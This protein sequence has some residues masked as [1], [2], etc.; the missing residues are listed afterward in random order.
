[1]FT[2]RRP[3]TGVFIFR[4]QPT[5]AFLTVCT[6]KR[7]RC[8]TDPAVHR[9]LL[10]A[11]SGSAAWMI[12]A[13]LLMPDHLHLFCMPLDESVEIEKWLTFWKR[14]FRRCHQDRSCQFQ[15]GCFHHRLRR[16]ES[17]AQRWDYV[18]Q[19]PVRAGLVQHPDDWAYGGVLNELRW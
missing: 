3:A 17:Y 7:S 16:P 18:R 19:N 2:R 13:Y 11:W 8:L 12:G 5:I 1:M 6:R 15:P 10:E 9:H 4:G 14:R